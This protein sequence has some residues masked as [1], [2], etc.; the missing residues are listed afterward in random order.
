[1]P[2]RLGRRDALA[3]DQ[4]GQALV[5][6]LHALA[7]TRLQRRIHLRYLAL[8]DQVADGRRAQH[9]LVRGHAAR[10]VCGAAQGLRHHALQRLR[11]HAAHH[12]FVLG[13]KDIDDAVHRL[14]GA[15]RVQRAQHQVAGFGRRQ[16]QANGVQVTQLA[17]QNHVR[18]F[19]QGSAQR[20]AEAVRV[21]ADLALVHD[22][23][24]GHMLKLDRVFYREDVPGARAVVKIHHRRQRGGLARARRP[25]HQHQPAR[26]ER[27]LGQHGRRT[28]RGQR[29]HRGRYAAKHCRCAAAL[30]ERIY[31]KAPQRRMRPRQVQLQ[32]LRKHLALLRCHHLAEQRRHIRLALHRPVQR[33]NLPMHAQHGRHAG[34]QMQIRSLA[35]QSRGEQ[36][37]QVH[38]GLIF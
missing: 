21:A 23:F 17:D 4:L 24:V 10:A 34:R 6:R 35:S 22:A 26:P 37:G 9:H 15:G 5:Q 16:R 33:F 28:Q 36:G 31:P 11:Q 29:R 7:R 20:G 1:M 8:A 2:A 18:V 14:G 32:R 30:H 19:T 38:G 25:R 12:L 27:Q 13:R 3:P